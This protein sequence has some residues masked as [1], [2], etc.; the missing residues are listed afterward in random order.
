M[1]GT[2]VS[3]VLQKNKIKYYA[4]D[5][6]V[7]IT[8]HSAIDQFTSARQIKWVLNCA[9]YTA[10]DDA[11]DNRELAYKI[12][13]LGPENLAAAAQKKEAVIIHI[14]TDYVFSGNANSPYEVDA[15]PD[16]TCVYGETKLAGEQSVRGAT[17]KYFIVR[18]AWLYGR[19]GSNF[20][21]TI[22]NLLQNKKE[23]RVVNDQRG[24]PTYAA[25]LAGALAAFIKNESD[26][27]GVFHYTNRGSIT[28]YDFA[29]EIY[30]IGRQCNRIYNRCSLV[31]ISSTD[32][33]TKARRPA[34]SVLSLGKIEKELNI[35]IP[36]WKDAL[37]RF[38][39]EESHSK[40]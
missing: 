18:T 12:N 33:P 7:D 25:D 15:V 30:E 35:L 17:N 16:P 34:Y 3:K 14:S 2:E 8:D 26:N 6:D 21:T 23:L 32:F 1:L 10:V 22:E 13:A 27:Y 9:A 5:L 39:T 29:N 37:R 4:T 24:A 38:F 20:V 31:P 11:E 19:H 36:D 28:W 40:E